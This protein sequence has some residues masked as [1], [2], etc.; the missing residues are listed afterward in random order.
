MNSLHH[1]SFHVLFFAFHV[2][3]PV[4][5]GPSS[6]PPLGLPKIA[7]AFA[8]SGHA[9]KLFVSTSQDFD[10]KLAWSDLQLVIYLF[11]LAVSMLAQFEP[12]HQKKHSKSF[13]L[14]HF[15]KRL[16]SVLLP[17]AVQDTNLTYKTCEGAA[18][19]GCM[20][21]EYWFLSFASSKQSFRQGCKCFPPA[22]PPFP[23]FVHPS[24]GAVFQFLLSVAESSRTVAR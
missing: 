21:P 9:G 12:P 17:A 4:H 10:C 23:V 11:L 2:G 15:K 16:R 20:C 24:F 18:F 5:C 6:Q 19:I 8:I 7:C 3:P 14:V 22:S 1:A 13:S